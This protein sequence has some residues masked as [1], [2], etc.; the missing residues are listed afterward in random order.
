[1][2][3][4][5]TPEL[6]EEYNTLFDECEI[7][8]DRVAAI[9]RTVQKIVA[10]Q[11][12]YEAVAAN[13]GTLPWY[14][15]A[16]VHNMESSLN[17]TTHL[18]NGD[19]LTARTFHV[20]AGRPVDGE[21]PFTWEFSATDSLKLEKLDKWNNWTVSGLL[22]QLE[23]YNGF[24]YRIHYPEVKTPYLWSFTNQYT[25][26]KY[27]KDNVFNADAV[28]DQCGVVA[29]LRHMLDSDIIVLYKN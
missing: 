27:V 23:R 10:N 5:L 1:M 20:P 12:R 29:L 15:I 13:I 22:Y 16:V 19:P 28:S 24:G 11:A 18:H 3:I 17:F 21:P 25:S 9:E 8:D 26:G 6:V 2:P 14:F 7:N 4:T